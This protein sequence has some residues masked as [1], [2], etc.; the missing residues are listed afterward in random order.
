MNKFINILLLLVGMPTMLVCIFIGF[1]LPM[2]WIGTSG[3]NMPYRFE[4]LLTLGLIL[5]VILLRRSVRRWMG[6]RLVNQVKRFKWNGVVST[7]RMQRVMT[8]N[9]LEAL[10]MLSFGTGLYGLTEE[11]WMP[12]LA[13]LFGG[14]DNLIFAI[15][16]R[17]NRK[18]RIGLTSKALMIA[19]REVIV[20][21]F[22]GLRRVTQHQQTIYFDFIKDLQ[23]RFPE[24]CV[25]KDQRDDFFETLKATLDPDKVYFSKKLAD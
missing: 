20:I 11:A 14:V 15:Y 24:D 9:F 22:T 19:D 8:Y 13:M 6:M 10:V 18:F 5:L 4:I 7:S 12:A 1:D 25:S 2:T 23:L 21:Y 17:A 16:G 3:A